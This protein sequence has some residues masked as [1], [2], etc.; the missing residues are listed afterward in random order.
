VAGK[1]IGMSLFSHSS[2]HVVI[3]GTMYPK[4]GQ[5]HLWL[6]GSAGS[7]GTTICP[8]GRVSHLIFNCVYADGVVIAHGGQ[9]RPGRFNCISAIG[10]KPN[11]AFRNGTRTGTYR[12]PN[13][14]T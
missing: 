11:E 8:R 14:T 5:W 12:A 6:H 1:G 9:A 4:I 10:N 13:K 3:D 7:D 2:G